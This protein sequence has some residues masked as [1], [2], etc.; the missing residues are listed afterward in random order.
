[1]VDTLHANYPDAEV[2][3]LVNKRVAELVSNYSNINKVHAIEKETAGEIKRICKANGYDLAIIVH[4]TFK[5]SIGVYLAGVKHRLGTRNRWYSFLFNIRHPQ[6]RK[7]SL[8]HEMEYNLDLLDA[9]NCFRIKGLKPSLNVRNEYTDTI[10]EMLTMKNIE[11]EFII[12]HIPSLGS[13]KVWSDNNFV[14]LINLLVENENP[15][16]VLA[17][18]EQDKLH[19][20]SILSQ[21][22]NKGRIFAFYGLSLNELAALIKLSKLF[23]SNSTGPIHIAAAV[24]TFVVGLYSPVK[25]ESPVRWGPVTDKKKIFAPEKDDDSRDVMDDIKVNDVADF[26]LDFL[27]SKGL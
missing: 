14:K 3:F 1:M 5:I 16:I 25:V 23:I 22:Q 8:K 9:I 20:A 6:H 17:G 2:D 4:P 19:I 27:K 21:F 15:N 24:G 12:I 26:I 11:Q 13:A 10:K 18:T 7:Y